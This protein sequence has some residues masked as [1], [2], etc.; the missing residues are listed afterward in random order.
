M[1]CRLKFGKPGKAAKADAPAEAGA[2]QHAHGASVSILPAVVHRPGGS[3]GVDE[4]VGL[5]TVAT[6]VTDGQ[7]CGIVPG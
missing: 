3:R 4:P 1:G 5:I 6:V 7:D 2:A